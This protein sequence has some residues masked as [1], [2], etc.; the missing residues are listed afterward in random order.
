[1][2]IYPKTFIHQTTFLN[3]ISLQISLQNNF[4]DKKEYNEEKK[5]VCET[6]KI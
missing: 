3:Q 4:C 2:Y 5:L 6:S 1:M